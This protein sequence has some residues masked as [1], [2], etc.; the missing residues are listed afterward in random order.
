MI[1][2][3]FRKSCLGVRGLRERSVDVLEGVYLHHWR[4]YPDSVPGFEA[5]SQDAEVF[6]VASS[7]KE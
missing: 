5:V 6:F 2:H 4:L 3:S 7:L 1:V